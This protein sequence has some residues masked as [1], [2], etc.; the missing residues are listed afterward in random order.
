VLGVGVGFAAGIGAVLVLEP[1]RIA[2]KQ[3][4]RVQT[5]PAHHWLMVVVAQGEL[6]RELLRVGRIAIL[7]VVKADGCPISAP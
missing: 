4:D 1:E 6:I 5:S 7:H 2:K 3:K